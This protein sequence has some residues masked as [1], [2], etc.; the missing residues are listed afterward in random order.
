M[1][2]NIILEVKDNEERYFAE[3]KLSASN[4]VVV[5]SGE[6]APNLHMSKG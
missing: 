2:L 3:N 1:K 5:Q 6:S 4:F